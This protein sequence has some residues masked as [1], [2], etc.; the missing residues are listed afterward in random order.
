MQLFTGFSKLSKSQK[1][2]WL[3]EQHLNNSATARE[4]L[5]QY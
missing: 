5:T 2:D 1:I 4:T 3:V